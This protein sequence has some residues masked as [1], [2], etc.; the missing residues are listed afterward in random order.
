MSSRV[1]SIVLHIPRGQSRAPRRAG[2]ASTMASIGMLPDGHA[3]VHLPGAAARTAHQRKEKGS[4]RDARS[5][6]VQTPRPPTSSSVADAPS[7]SDGSTLRLFNGSAYVAIASERV[8]MSITIRSCSRDCPFAFLFWTGKTGHLALAHTNNG[9]R[10]DG[11][12]LRS[13]HLP[14]SG[15]PSHSHREALRVSCAPACPCPMLPSPTHAYYTPI[16]V[17]PI[18]PTPAYACGTDPAC[19][20]NT[21]TTATLSVRVALPHLPP[22]P[23][24]SSKLPKSTQFQPTPLFYSPFPPE[25][26]LL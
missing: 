17:H 7:V 19:T 1:E 4:S 21:M 2:Y 25:T 26:L 22:P 20:S 9:A 14:L 12:T 11:Q 8:C 23:S 15:T 3:Y 6:A 16:P 5:P 24:T 13:A 10:V 18:I